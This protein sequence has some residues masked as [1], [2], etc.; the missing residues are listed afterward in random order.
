MKRIYMCGEVPSGYTMGLAKEYVFLP[1]EHV[2]GFR[3]H[4][5][6]DS[7]SV[8]VLHTIGGLTAS[9]LWVPQA[10]Q[11]EEEAKKWIYENFK[12][13]FEGVCPEPE[14]FTKYGSSENTKIE[15]PPLS[16]GTN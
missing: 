14:D 1:I 9:P 3:I 13:I 4:N 15:R 16:G 7:V 12:E 11:T 8:E 5:F 6:G 10:F 2:I